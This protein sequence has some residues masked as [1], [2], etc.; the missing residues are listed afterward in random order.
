MSR[1]LFIPGRLHHQPAAT[2]SRWVSELVHA[3]SGAEGGRT[4][5][6]ML[7]RRPR[8]TCLMQQ[9]PHNGL[10]HHS[11]R[12]REACL[13]ATIPRACPLLRLNSRFQD[14]RHCHSN[15]HRLQH[16]AQLQPLLSPVQL[17]NQAST[18]LMMNLLPLTL[19]ENLWP[20]LLHLC[21]I[22]TRSQHRNRSQNRHLEWAHL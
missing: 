21:Q 19:S 20:S 8:E 13:L 10:M 2:P 1:T 11:H 12:D 18:R 16:P 14:P 5:V 15:A 3:E 22:L 7:R 17:L 6:S 9:V 4:A